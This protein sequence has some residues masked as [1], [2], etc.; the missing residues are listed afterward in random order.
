MG[1]KTHTR[2]FQP[3]KDVA[4]KDDED[5]GLAIEMLQVKILI[6]TQSNHKSEV[7]LT[8]LSTRNGSLIL[9][10]VINFQHTIFLLISTLFMKVLVT[11]KS[12]SPLTNTI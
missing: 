12:Q 9:K 2:N 6:G 4:A 1:V 10:F 7:S 3:V 8:K 5:Q 11:I